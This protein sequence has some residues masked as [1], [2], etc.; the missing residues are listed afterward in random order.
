MNKTPRGTQ[1]RWIIVGLG[2]AVTVLIWG[3]RPSLAGWSSPNASPPSST[4][5]PPLTTGLLHQTKAGGLTFINDLTVEQPVTT[6]SITAGGQ[7]SIIP[8]GQLCLKGQCIYNWGML[9]GD[10]IHLYDSD[11]PGS[12]SGNPSL[13]GK[14]KIYSE[15]S[16]FAVKGQAATPSL[17][18]TAGLLGNSS[19]DPEGTQ[20]TIGVQGL[21]STRQYCSDSGD[22]CSEATPCP[23]GDCVSTSQSYGVW[24]SDGG[25]TNPIPFVDSWA[26]RFDGRVGIDGEL[27]L[28]DDCRSSWPPATLTDYV[29][30]QSSQVATLETQPGNIQILG[31]L[32]SGH[33]VL[34]QPPA[35]LSPALSCGDGFCT[36]ANG[37]YSGTCAVDCP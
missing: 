8:G 34:G 35:G 13:I 16:T 18:P 5:A 28:N 1:I 4:V 30:V 21:A 2:L 27:C 12:D 26:G 10:Y 37:E 15:D 17:E 23:T 7:T 24:G 3:V 36:S 20:K 22:E 9:G 19:N 25:L 32:K 31:T 14:A 29:R 11:D 33:I 6:D